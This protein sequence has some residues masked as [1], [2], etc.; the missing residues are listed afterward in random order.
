MPVCAKMIS[1]WV[2]EALNIAKAHVSPNTLQGSVPS[3][4]LVAGVSLVSILQAGGCATVSTLARY[5]FSI[6]ITPSYQH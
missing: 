6:Y 4:G 2:R 1:S 5:Y 3:A